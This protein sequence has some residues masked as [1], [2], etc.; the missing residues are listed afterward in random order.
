MVS[1]IGVVAWKRVAVA[2]QRE[3][4][5]RLQV[6][7]VRA[8]EHE[9]VAQHPVAAPV[10]RQRREA[11]EDEVRPAARLADH[12][13]DLGDELLEAGGRSAGGRP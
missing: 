7:D 10:L 6:V 2:Q 13:V 9:E 4:G 12:A 8:G 5:Q 1:A 11:V 3:V